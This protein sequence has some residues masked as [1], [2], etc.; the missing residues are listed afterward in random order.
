MS[1]RFE[2]SCDAHLDRAA[3]RHYAEY[4]VLDDLNEFA[5]ELIEEAL[6]TLPGEELVAGMQ[7]VEL[8]DAERIRAAYHDDKALAA[9]VRELVKKSITDSASEKARKQ[10]AEHH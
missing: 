7:S 2:T 1:R 6:R 4:D 3:G 8:S 10:F 9:L 5:G